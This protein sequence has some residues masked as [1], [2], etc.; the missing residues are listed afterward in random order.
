ML[1]LFPFYVVAISQEMCVKRNWGNS[2]GVTDILDE[3]RIDF[4]DWSLFIRR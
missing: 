1:D 3:K 2:L 4:E